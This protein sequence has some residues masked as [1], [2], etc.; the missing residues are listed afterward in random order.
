MEYTDEAGSKEIG[1][2][3]FMKYTSDNAVDSRKQAVE[4]R[5][6]FQK[7]RTEFPGDGKYTMAMRNVDDFKRHR[8]SPV[9]G[10]HVAAGRTKTRMTAERNILEISA[11]RAGI[12]GIT[13]G[14]IATVNHFFYVLDD[15]VTRMLKINHFFKM[16]RK[17]LL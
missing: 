12:H 4:K 9:D 17:N 8:S 6:I 5:A 15:R 7:E 11:T 14:R 2:I 1:F 3:I 13:K 10:V 16:V